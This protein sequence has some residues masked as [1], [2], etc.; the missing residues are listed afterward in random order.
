M[1]SRTRWIASLTVSPLALLT[2]QGALA[3]TD[4][5]A[6]LKDAQ[7]RD[8]VVITGKAVR[9]PSPTA[10]VPTSPK[11]LDSFKP[12]LPPEEAPR[13]VARLDLP[14]PTRR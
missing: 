10:W 7:R 3:F 9:A 6:D 2:L 8:R 4:A 11:R 13:P 12:V 5:N 1:N 14:A